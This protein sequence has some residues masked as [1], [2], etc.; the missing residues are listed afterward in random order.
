[1]IFHTSLLW[2][3]PVSAVVPISVLGIAIHPPGQ[4]MVE[5]ILDVVLFVP[6][7]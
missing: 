1:M 5:A 4:A 7:M 3:D 2:P 6:C